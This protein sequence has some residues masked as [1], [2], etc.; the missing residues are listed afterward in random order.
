MF[1]LENCLSHSLNGSVI[2]LFIV[3]LKWLFP[4]YLQNMKVDI[5]RCIG[6]PWSRELTSSESWISRYSVLS[7][8]PFLTKQ[9]S[10]QQVKCGCLSA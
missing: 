2:G 1:L 9:F 7:L 6:F 8:F 4:N 3:H 5:I 10:F